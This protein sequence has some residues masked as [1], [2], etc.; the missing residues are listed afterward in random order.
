MFNI[1]EFRTNA[2]G[3]DV[4]PVSYTHLDVYKRQFSESLIV[5]RDYY[6]QACL[7]TIL[8]YLFQYPRIWGRVYFVGIN[9][10]N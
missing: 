5:S 6:F 1:V 8:L 10:R 9:C 7:I 3:Y 2:V 4:I